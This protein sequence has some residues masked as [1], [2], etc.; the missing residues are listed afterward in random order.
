MR[1]F[2]ALCSASPITAEFSWYVVEEEE[3]PAMCSADAG[4]EEGDGEWRRVDCL[5]SSNFLQSGRTEWGFMVILGQ[6]LNMVF[7][8]NLISCSAFG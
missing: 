5:L 6:N 7:G 1:V 8:V 4:G 3:P 2:P